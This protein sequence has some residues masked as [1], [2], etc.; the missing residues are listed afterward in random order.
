MTPSLSKESSEQIYFPE[1]KREIV[2]RMK[3]QFAKKDV[4]IKYVFN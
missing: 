4:T 2:Y 3:C 1:V